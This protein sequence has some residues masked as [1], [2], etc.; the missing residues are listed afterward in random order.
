MLAAFGGGGIVITVLEQVTGHQQNEHARY[1]VGDL[2]VDTGTH[3]VARDGQPV[4]CEFLF[5]L[6][7]AADT[8]RDSRI[9]TGNCPGEQCFDLCSSASGQVLSR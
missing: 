5:K 6:L 1:R 8:N 7:L 2:I 3:T 9:S 4:G